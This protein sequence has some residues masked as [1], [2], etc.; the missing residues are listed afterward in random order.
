[1]EM[2]ISWNVTLVIMLANVTLSQSREEEI[3]T[4]IAH[5]ESK[6]SLF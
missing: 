3:T 2:N 5:R 6:T 1:M 4:Q